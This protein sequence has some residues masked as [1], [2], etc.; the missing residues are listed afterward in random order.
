LGEGVGMGV[1]YFGIYIT[2]GLLLMATFQ[3]GLNFGKSHTFGFKKY[4]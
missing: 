1:M 4:Q 3:D 2:F